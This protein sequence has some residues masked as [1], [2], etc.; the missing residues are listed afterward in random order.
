MVSCFVLSTRTRNL[1]QSIAHRAYALGS[2]NSLAVSNGDLVRR[3]VFPY[4][5]LRV[6]FFSFW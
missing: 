3:G 5:S 6:V 4:E 2:N 1:T